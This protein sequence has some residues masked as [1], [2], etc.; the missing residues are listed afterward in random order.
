MCKCKYKLF[1]YNKLKNRLKKPDKKPTKK[2]TKKLPKKLPNF[3]GSFIIY[4]NIK[5]LFL[6]KTM[7]KKY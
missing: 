4:K 1:L 7:Y 2:P 6:L 5:Y 3:F